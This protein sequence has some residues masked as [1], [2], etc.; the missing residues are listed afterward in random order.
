VKRIFRWVGTLSG[1]ALIGTVVVAVVLG[2]LAWGLY[3]W[4]V[5][6]QQ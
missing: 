3:T 2:L 5:L 1:V 4:F 6:I